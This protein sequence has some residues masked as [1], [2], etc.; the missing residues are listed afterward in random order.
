M[1]R[2][3]RLYPGA[4]MIRAYRLYPGADMIR[5]YRLYPGADGNSHV[6]R[7]SVSGD[8]LVEAESILFKETPAHASL[9][10]HTAPVPQYVITLAGVLEFTT[11]GGETFTIRPGD[12]LLAVDYT[13]SGHKWRLIKDEP[14]KRA[15]VV[16]K[17]GAGPTHCPHGRR[18]IFPTHGTG[19]LSNDPAEAAGPHL[20]D[21]QPWVHDRG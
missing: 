7:G 2:A 4:D 11:R 16:F 14:W 19:G 21:Q 17:Q 13:G 10:W 9:D 8:A 3:Y 12:V 15:Y 6:V 18:R 20:P 5:A 1:I